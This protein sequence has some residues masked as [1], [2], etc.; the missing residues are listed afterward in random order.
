[1]EIIYFGEIR[2]IHFIRSSTSWTENFCPG[3][4]YAFHIPLWR[5]EHSSGTLAH[6]CYPHSISTSDKST[7]HAQ[8]LK[9]SSFCPQKQHQLVLLLTHQPHCVGGIMHTENS[10]PSEFRVWKYQAWWSVH[11]EQY[12]PFQ[13]SELCITQAKG[14]LI[15]SNRWSVGVFLKSKSRSRKAVF[16]IIVQEKRKDWSE[17][18]ENNPI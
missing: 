2:E 5:C 4:L 9:A 10:C 12:N 13:A 11:R 6:S 3:G 8:S 15:A 17:N 18:K 16:C 7:Y 1:M 14:L